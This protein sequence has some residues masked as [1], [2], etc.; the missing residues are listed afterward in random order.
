MAV[1][2]RKSV[3]K[4]FLIRAVYEEQIVF[5]LSGIH[6]VKLSVQLE[7]FS[8]SLQRAS[9]TQIPIAVPRN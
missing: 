6:E 3:G 1:Y 7:N 5:E 4:I 8:L 9:R 2:G